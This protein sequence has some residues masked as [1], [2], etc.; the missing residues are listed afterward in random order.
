MCAE[1]SIIPDA[2]KTLNKVGQVRTKITK[3]IP[4]RSV[5]IHLHSKG[6]KTKGKATATNELNNH[7]TKGEKKTRRKTTYKLTRSCKRA[8]SEKDRKTVI[9]FV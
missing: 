7:G 3:M 5:V 2:G 8:K 1:N 4:P 9:F 6:N